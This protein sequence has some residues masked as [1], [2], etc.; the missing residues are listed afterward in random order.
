MRGRAAARAG[1]PPAG[2]GRGGRGAGGG[3]P[4]RPRGGG[5]AG[6]PRWAIPPALLSSCSTRAATRA[7]PRS[8]VVSPGL[9]AARGLGGVGRQLAALEPAGLRAQVRVSWARERQ[10]GTADEA[11]A[12]LA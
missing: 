5:R 9:A 12:V 10:V 11:A 7:G 4:C 2:R 1:P 6:M 3:R 8:T